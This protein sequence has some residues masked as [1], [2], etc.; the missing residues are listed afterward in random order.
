MRAIA[1]AIAVA[2]T[3]Q[4]QGSAPLPAGAERAYTALKDRVD[5]NAAMDVVRFMDRSWRIA[6][7]PGFNASVDYIREALTGAGLDSRVEEFPLRGRGWDYERGTVSLADSGEVVLSKE[8]DRV[9]LCINEMWARN[10][11]P[12]IGIIDSKVGSLFVMKDHM[13]KQVEQLPSTHTRTT[14]VGAAAIG[15]QAIGAQAIK[16]QGIGGLAIGALA[17]G[18]VA[19]GTLA[20]GRLIIGRLTIRRTRLGAVEIDELHVGRLHVR[21]LLVDDQR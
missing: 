9:S 21:E 3:L 11:R 2:I 12:V 14:A 16:A 18:A 6:G 8:T 5:G 7:N 17:I 15:A 1:G 19:I 4:A 10:C 13:N 20:V